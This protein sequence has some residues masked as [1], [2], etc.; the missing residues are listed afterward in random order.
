MEMYSTDN[1]GHYPV[2]LGQLTPKYLKTLPECPRAGAVTYR[3][4]TGQGPMNNPG[5]ED[6]YYVECHG[7]NHTNVS[8]SG[9]YPA[10]DAISGLIERPL[11]AP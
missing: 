1:Q 9:N 2:N 3:V 4:Y 5:F 6:Y 7:G 10:Y 8:I 11:K